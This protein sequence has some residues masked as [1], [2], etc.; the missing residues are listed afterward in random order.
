MNIFGI[1]DPDPDPHENLCGSETL[2]LPLFYPIFTCVDPIR[3]R[4][5]NTACFLYDL[6]SVSPS[7]AVVRFYYVDNAGRVIRASV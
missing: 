5:H 6:Q 1:Q 2:L 4:I 7:E 3:I